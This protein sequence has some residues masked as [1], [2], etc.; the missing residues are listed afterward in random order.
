M[1][2]SKESMQLYVVSDRTWL[3]GRSLYEVL[4]Q[5]LQAGATFLQL[6]EKDVTNEFFLQEALELQ[7]LAKQYHVPFVINDNIEV[8]IACNADGVHIGQSDGSVKDARTKI[9]NDKILGVSVQSVKQALK[10]QEDGA[11]Y[12]GVGAMFVTSTKEDADKVSMHSLKAICEAVT[13]PVVAIGGIHASNI[14]D[15]KESKCHGVAI[16]S[17]ILASIDIYG[18]TKELLDLTKE[19]FYESDS[20]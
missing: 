3:E 9:G 10:A 7:V 14:K 4:E 13:I 6:R 16:I 18:S 19:C 15:L 1:H 17:A 2:V 20:I 8:A 5:T 11:D 12:L